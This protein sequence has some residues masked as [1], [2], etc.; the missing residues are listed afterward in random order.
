MIRALTSAARLPVRQPS[1]TTT[2]RW[3]FASE[4]RMGGGGGGSAPRAPPPPPGAASPGG[5]PLRQ[6]A[7]IGDERH[8]VAGAAHRRAPDLRR[9]RGLVHLALGRVERRVLADHD[10][11]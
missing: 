3:V 4:A 7:A 6:R 11:G 1:S 2:T 9:A 5:A 8:G 10:G